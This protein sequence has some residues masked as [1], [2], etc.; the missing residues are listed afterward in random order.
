[1]TRPDDNPDVFDPNQD[2]NN[3]DRNTEP[4]REG[5]QQPAEPDRPSR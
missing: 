4:A 5:E 2:P 3:P 1:M